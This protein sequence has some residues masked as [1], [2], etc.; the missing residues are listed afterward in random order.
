MIEGIMEKDFPVVQG[1]VL[2][3]AIAY[4]FANFIVDIT[5]YIIVLRQEC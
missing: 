1:S 2:F 3:A 5:Y 4:M